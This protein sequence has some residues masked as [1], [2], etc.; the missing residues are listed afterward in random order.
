MIEVWE[1]IK[2]SII[3]SL[4]GL[5][6]WALTKLLKGY[7]RNV[8]ETIEK[9]G[10]LLDDIRNGDV[11]VLYQQPEICTR[12]MKDFEIESGK[13]DGRLAKVENIAN[14]NLE[15]I[16][17]INGRLD[18]QEVNQKKL[19][20]KIGNIENTVNTFDDKWKVE[21]KNRES[22]TNSSLDMVVAFNK[23]TQ[24]V[25]EIGKELLKKLEE[26]RNEKT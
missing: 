18:G 23:G 20:S 7:F 26:R 15:E 16:V 9:Q 4:S 22:L 19:L 17:K 13:K 3:I 25:E 6:G 5:G 2:T 21:K 1:I 12:F 14:G 8:G 10:K 24:A 11:K